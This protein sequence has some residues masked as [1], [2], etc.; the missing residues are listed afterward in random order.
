MEE[1]ELFT[2]TYIVFNFRKRRVQY[3]IFIFIYI[4]AFYKQLS[5]QY[6]N[7]ENITHTKNYNTHTEPDTLFE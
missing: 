4:H 7:M 3:Q 5:K 1:F 2:G 6:N